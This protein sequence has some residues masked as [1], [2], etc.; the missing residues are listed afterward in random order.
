MNNNDV[1]YS[2]IL[3]YRHRAYLPT[4]LHTHK[5]VQNTPNKIEVLLH[6]ASLFCGLNRSITQSCAPTAGN[7]R[8]V[9]LPSAQTICDNVLCVHRSRTVKHS[10][11]PRADTCK[12][13]LFVSKD[14]EVGTC[15]L[16]T[17]NATRAPPAS[18]PTQV[19]T[20]LG[21]GGEGFG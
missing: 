12:P 8:V 10:A 13:R 5:I 14:N 4:V 15:K 1:S 11:S 2:T 18:S 9:P 6:A 17:S 3:S 7:L 20:E 19:K 21:G 16:L